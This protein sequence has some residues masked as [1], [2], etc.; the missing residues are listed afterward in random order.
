MYKSCK[1]TK[2]QWRID[3]GR[4]R[5]LA[6][7]AGA[8]LGAGTVPQIASMQDFRKAHAVTGA[9][10]QVCRDEREK[11]LRRGRSDDATKHRKNF[12]LRK[13]TRTSRWK[14]WP[15]RLWKSLYST[16]GFAECTWKGS[17]VPRSSHGQ[18]SWSIHTANNALTSYLRN[19]SSSEFIPGGNKEMQPNHAQTHPT[20]LNCHTGKTG[21]GKEREGDFQR[22]ILLNNVNRIV[23]RTNTTVV[24]QI[25]VAQALHQ[26][27]DELRRPLPERTGSS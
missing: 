6:K 7:T 9:A 12:S 21:R 24:A 20:T 2:W 17:R 5:T 19:A 18:S 15:Q 3:G 13:T 26:Q 25:C 4:V 23:A 14:L 22:V 11:E 10:I 1:I 27:P 8:V 16:E